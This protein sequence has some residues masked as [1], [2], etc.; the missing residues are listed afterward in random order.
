MG[1]Q[2]TVRLPSRLSRALKAASRRLRRRPSEVVRL[3]LEAYLGPAGASAI[4]PADR[5]RALIG[6][7][8]SGVPDLAERY[9]K[10]LLA[11]LKRGR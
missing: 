1:A 11:S 6:S 9:R 5:V 2:L 8:E 4:R 10:Y 3:A 7:V